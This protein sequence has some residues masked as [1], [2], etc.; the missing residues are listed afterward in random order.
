MI[1]ADNP[2]DNQCIISKV[3]N[4]NQKEHQF[5]D[6]KSD[7]ALEQLKNIVQLYLIGHIRPLP[8]FKMASPIKDISKLPDD[9]QDD[10]RIKMLYG[11]ESENDLNDQWKKAFEEFATFAYMGNGIVEK[12]EKKS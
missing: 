2:D 6:F 12:K 8:L 10:P 9:I 1:C 3:L 5:D 11:W 7:E 4:K